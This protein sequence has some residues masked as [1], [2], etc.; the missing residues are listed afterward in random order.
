MRKSRGWGVEELRQTGSSSLTTSTTKAAMSNSKSSGII[1]GYKSPY[2]HMRITPMVRRSYLR[3]MTGYMMMGQ[4]WDLDFEAMARVVGMLDE[5]EI[6]I[7]RKEKN[8]LTL[9]DFRT[10]VVLWDESEKVAGIG[11]SKSRANAAA[12]EREKNGNDSGNGQWL[13]WRVF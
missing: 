5:S 9:E 6:D 10:V 1:Q 13:S 2:F 12:Y 7:N 4:Y 3:N 11:G 8:G